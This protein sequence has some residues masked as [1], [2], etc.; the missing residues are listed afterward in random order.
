MSTAIKK[1]I[2]KLGIGWKK[3]IYQIATT[4]RFRKFPN[5]YE[6][7]KK[8]TWRKIRGHL[9]TFIFQGSP[10]NLEYNIIGLASN[11][12]VNFSHKGECKIDNIDNIREH[13]MLE[14]KQNKSQNSEH[15]LHSRII[16]EHKYVKQTLSTSRRSF[17]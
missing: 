11:K 6:K 8:F 1:V 16:L 7:N 2:L 10:H 9:K 14:W 13:V 15:I 17:L 4:H 5:L 3:T 12:I